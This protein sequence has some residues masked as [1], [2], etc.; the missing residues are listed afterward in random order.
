MLWSIHWRH[1]WNV[2]FEDTCGQCMTWNI[3]LNT[4]LGD[5][6]VGILLDNVCFEV[7]IEDTFGQCILWSVNLIHFWT[8]T[9]LRGPLKT[10]V[11]VFIEDTF[12]QCMLWIIHWGHFWT[13]YALEYSLRS[14]MDNVRFEAFIEYN[15]LKYSLNSFL[16]NVC[17]EAF[18]EDT[19]WQLKILLDNEQLIKDLFGQCML[20]S[21][22][23]IHFW[24][25]Y[26]LRNSFNTLFDNV[27]F[28]GLIEHTFG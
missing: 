22:H 27:C 11:E 28:E 2:C 20:W 3:Y 12:G 6:R 14:H 19:F 18:V 5:I 4:L 25:M 1:F 10:L 26:A 15:A 9:S 17:F 7:F 8:M 23:W 16:D 21:I 13:M 24:T